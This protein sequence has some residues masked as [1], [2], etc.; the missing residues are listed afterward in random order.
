[1][2]AW[3]CGMGQP[4]DYK[5]PADSSVGCICSALVLGKITQLD[6]EKLE[7]IERLRVQRE[8]ARIPAALERDIARLNQVAA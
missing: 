3:K 5:I 1:M 4:C 2:T 7:Q 6:V 8:I